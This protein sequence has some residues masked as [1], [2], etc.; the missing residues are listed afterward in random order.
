MIKYYDLT[1]SLFLGILKLMMMLL[2]GLS[3]QK[4][5]IVISFRII[6]MMYLMIRYHDLVCNFFSTI[7][8]SMIVLLSD[9]SILKSMMMPLLAPSISEI[10]DSAP[11]EP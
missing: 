9:L 6:Y 2:L 4:S 10:S 1:Y 11:P 5:M 7:L 3:I 8:K